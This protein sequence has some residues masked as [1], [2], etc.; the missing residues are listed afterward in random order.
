VYNL[1]FSAWDKTSGVCVLRRRD[2]EIGV[3]FSGVRHIRAAAVV[4]KVLKIITRV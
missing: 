1:V 2:I 3:D 4:R